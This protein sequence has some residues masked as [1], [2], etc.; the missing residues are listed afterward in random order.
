MLICFIITLPCA[1]ILALSLSLA[2]GTEP[3]QIR[4]SETYALTDN[5]IIAYK[6]DFCQDLRT[7]STKASVN[8]Q[9]VGNLYFLKSRP[10]LTERES[11]NVSG[12]TADLSSKGN[13]RY[14]NFYLN[15]G[16][17]ASFTVCYQQNVGTRRDVI[18]YIIRGTDQLNNWIDKPR[19]RFAEESYRLTS[20]CDTITYQVVQDEM[21]YFVFYL[22]A[23]S[24]SSVNVNFTISRTLY[25]ILPDNIINECSFDLDGSSSCVLSV[26]MNSGY[27]AALSLNASRPINYADDG[28]EIL[29]SCQARAWLFAVIVLVV[30]L[31]GTCIYVGGIAILFKMAIYYKNKSTSRSQVTNVATT[32]D[33]AMDLKP[34]STIP[35]PIDYS[36][37]P[38]AYPRQPGLPPYS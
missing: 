8:Q 24:F 16:S 28:A 4:S 3:H 12:E 19:D 18:F 10:P 30:L 36:S 34:S 25:S 6:G 31:V 7:S 9:S 17:E 26:P 32:S 38:P 2:L 29:I 13:F 37:P 27:T 35:P 5:R 33:F 23:G 1:V 20:N 21:H 14:W 22:S 15:T 11:F